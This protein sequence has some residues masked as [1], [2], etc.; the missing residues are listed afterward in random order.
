MG[1]SSLVRTRMPVSVKDVHPPS[2]AA[3]GLG[4]VPDTGKLVELPETIE[5]FDYL[6][7][8]VGDELPEVAFHMTGN[9][10]EALELYLEDLPESAAIPQITDVTVGEFAIA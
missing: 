4:D 6:L 7:E 8:G 1:G 10:K 5:G 2:S 3:D 9:L